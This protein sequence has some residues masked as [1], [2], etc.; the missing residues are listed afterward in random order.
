[1]HTSPDLAECHSVDANRG[2]CKTYLLK[3]CRHQQ[4]LEVDHR[5]DL[6]LLQIGLSIFDHERSQVFERIAGVLAGQP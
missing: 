1:M 3:L 6:V 4:P 2:R 5:S